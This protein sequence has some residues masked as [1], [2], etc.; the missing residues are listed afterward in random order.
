MSGGDLGN[1][2]RGIGCRGYNYLDLA[3]LWRVRSFFC[4]IKDCLEKIILIE[5][6]F[7]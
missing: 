7:E 2:Y 4:V 6:I 1:I 3:R 5:R